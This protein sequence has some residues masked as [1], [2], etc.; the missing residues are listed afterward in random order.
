M[1]P[2][3]AKSASFLVSEGPQS[4]GGPTT[5]ADSGM[6]AG[7]SGSHVFESE[8]RTEPQIRQYVPPHSPAGREGDPSTDPD[9]DVPGHQQKASGD[10]S[11]T[12]V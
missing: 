5:A 4:Q 11:F 10:G 6:I 9:A 12:W 1:A 3:A 8:L 2:Y 7:P